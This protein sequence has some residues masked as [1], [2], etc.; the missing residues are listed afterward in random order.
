MGLSCGRGRDSVPSWDVGTLPAEDSVPETG[1]DWS[2]LAGSGAGDVSATGYSSDGR[3][4]GS[5]SFLNRG[6]LRRLRRGLDGIR[7]GLARWLLVR[8]GRCERLGGGRLRGGFLRCAVGGRGRGLLGVGGRRGFRFRVF[9]F[10]R[11]IVSFESFVRTHHKPFLNSNFFSHQ[12][13]RNLRIRR[14]AD[15]GAK[16]HRLGKLV[17][18][19]IEQETPRGFFVRRQ[20]DS[21]ANTQ[22]KPTASLRT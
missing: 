3:S 21:F 12:F 15:S 9:S 5:L 20:G 4:R 14:L 18:G 6:R 11:H 1:S 2:A 16:R 19:K 13:L 10:R 22:R 8:W 17:Q 7:S